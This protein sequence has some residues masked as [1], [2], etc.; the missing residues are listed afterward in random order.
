MHG[1]TAKNEYQIAMNESYLAFSFGF[2]RSS[3]IPGGVKEAWQE[4]AA[5]AVWGPLDPAGGC[6]D[7]CVGGVGVGVGVG[8]GG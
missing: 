7:G 1:C 8:V 5:E 2:D 6:M 4:P 3:G